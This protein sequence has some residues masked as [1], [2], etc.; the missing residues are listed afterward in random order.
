MAV[1]SLPQLLQQAAALSSFMHDVPS[2]LQQDIAFSPAQQE[3]LPPFACLPWR[4]HIFMSFESDEAILSQQAH[5]CFS[6]L[7]C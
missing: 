6:V 3:P 4:A 7:V 1:L 5:F 2:L